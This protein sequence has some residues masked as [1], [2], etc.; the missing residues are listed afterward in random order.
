MKK[1]L[2]TGIAGQDGSYLAEF[3]LDKD[4]EVYGVEKSCSILPVQIKSRIKYC[5][6]ID[7]T[8]PALLKKII[9]EITPD[10]IYHLAAYHFSSQNEGN[11]NKSFKQ[12]YLINLLATN[13]ILETIKVYLHGCRFFYA[14]SGQIFGKTDC[15]PQNEHTP[16][17]PDSLYTITKAAGTNLCQFYREHHGIYASVG[18]LYNHES[19]R[20][21]LSFVTAQIAISA[22][23]AF[24]GVPVKLVL[25]DLDAKVDWGAAQDYVRAMWLTLQQ[26][27]SDDYI[28]SS[29]VSHSVREFAK[30]AFNT[31]GL[32]SND[33]VS[34]ELNVKMNEKIPFVGDPSKIKNKCN[35]NSII[36]FDCLVKEMVDSYVDLLRSELTTF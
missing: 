13:E 18:I 11:K 14:S 17:R 7:I 19:F 24:L 22:A 2:I 16:F 4:Y 6:D 5:Y 21:P 33:F 27:R 34:Q 12:F 15:F 36:S 31:V 10:E 32:N 23:K 29:G 28:V 8:K 30:I 1:A 26:P 3:L 35:W 25:R 20:R 9:R